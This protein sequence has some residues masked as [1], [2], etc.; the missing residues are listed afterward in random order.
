V[1][2]NDCVTKLQAARAAPEGQ[3]KIPAGRLCSIQAVIAGI[4]RLS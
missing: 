2:H 3:G 1:Q 4:I